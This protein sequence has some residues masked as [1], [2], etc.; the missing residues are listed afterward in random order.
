MKWKII[1]FK[2]KIFYKKIKKLCPICATV[3][4]KKFEKTY[5]PFAPPYN[6]QKTAAKYLDPKRTWIDE[7]ECSYN[8]N[9]R[10][11]FDNNNNI[12]ES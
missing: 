8:F 7:D 4:F 12:A 11:C 3:L 5:V 2:L 10:P 9:Q 6:L 1:F